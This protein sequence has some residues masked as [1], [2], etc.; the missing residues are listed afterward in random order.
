MIQFQLIDTYINNQEY[1]FIHLQNIYKFRSSIQLTWSY[2]ASIRSPSLLAVFLINL[3][4]LYLWFWLNF[5]CHEIRDLI[6][7]WSAFCV[8]SWQFD[9]KALMFW[10]CLQ[11]TLDDDTNNNYGGYSYHHHYNYT[12]TFL[13]APWTEHT[14]LETVRSQILTQQVIY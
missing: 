4:N 11:A 8:S 9:G 10:L 14:I 5:N 2:S 6:G 12:F 7:F 1:C 3:W 13:I